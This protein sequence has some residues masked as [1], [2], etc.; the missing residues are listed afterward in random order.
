MSIVTPI[1]STELLKSKNK[2]FKELPVFT[3]PNVTLTLIVASF[4]D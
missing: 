3:D 2:E 4:F 1:I